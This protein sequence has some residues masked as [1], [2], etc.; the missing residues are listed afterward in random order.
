MTAPVEGEG[1]S[2]STEVRQRRRTR[3]TISVA[4]YNVR[5]GRR[6]GL[7]SAVRALRRGRVDVA[8]L[9]ET[10]IAKAKFAPRTHEGYTIRV[11]PSS[12]KNCG[13]VGLVYKETSRFLLKTRK[14]WGRTWCHSTS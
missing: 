6:G 11:A 7:Y 9:Q 10:K 3:G 1:A 5:D 12:G 8:I 14:S 13:G 4:S 2:A